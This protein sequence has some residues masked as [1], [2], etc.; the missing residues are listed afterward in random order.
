MKKF[1]P[2]LV[3]TWDIAILLFSDASSWGAGQAIY[4]VSLNCVPWCRASYKS[5]FSFVEKKVFL[6]VR[7]VADVLCRR[8]TV[9]PLSLQLWKVVTVI[10]VSFFNWTWTAKAAYYH[11]KESIFG[12][13]CHTQQPGFLVSFRCQL[14][15]ST[16]PHWHPPPTPVA[17]SGMLQTA[18]WQNAATL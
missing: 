16:R 2:V 17:S 6:G 7:C 12:T 11:F 5:P 8:L 18:P 15:G 13:G 9:N 3:D 4:G 1:P 10:T 14:R